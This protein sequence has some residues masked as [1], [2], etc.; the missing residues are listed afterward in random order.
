MRA[1]MELTLPARIRKKGR[2]FV[3]SCEVLDVHSQGKTRA[4]AEQNLR[5]ALE[6]FLVSCHE[7]GTLDEVLRESGFVAIT[8]KGR[9]L[10]SRTAR[11]AP[12]R[13]PL[14]F[15]IRHSHLRAS[16]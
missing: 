4:E 7:R 9:D 10:S 2:W 16:A 8:G 11:S 3:S 13:V 12:L 6:S 14:N 15:A 5:D 1:S